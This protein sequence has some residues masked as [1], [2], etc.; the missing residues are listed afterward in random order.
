MDHRNGLALRC[1]ILTQSSWLRA[2]SKVLFVV[3]KIGLVKQMTISIILKN[4]RD[5]SKYTDFFSVAQQPNSDLGRLV[6]KFLDQ[7][8]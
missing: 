1:K 3:K 7:T 4:S 5:F 2:V 8:Q 6:L